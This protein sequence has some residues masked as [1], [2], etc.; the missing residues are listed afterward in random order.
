MNWA[1]LRSSTAATRQ[2]CAYCGQAPGP[3]EKLATCAV[4]LGV[5][6]CS[7][8]CQEADWKAGHRELCRSPTRGGGLPKK[9]V[10]AFDSFMVRAGASELKRR[11]HVPLTIDDV[12][13]VDGDTYDAKVVAVVDPA[14]TPG[15][16]DNVTVL[17]GQVSRRGDSGGEIRFARADVSAL[18]SHD[19]LR[20]WLRENRSGL[21]R[22]RD[23][24]AGRSL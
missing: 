22:L 1:S 11:M 15:G 5:G 10:D 4:C 12:V 18:K 23:A 13:H 7:G 2:E 16:L 19:N 3:G 21:R 9:D 6:Y 20:T 8:K 24:L 14:T 17:A